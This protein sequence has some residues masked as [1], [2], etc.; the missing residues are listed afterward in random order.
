MQNSFSLQENK[1]SIYEITSDRR[2]A[3]PVRLSSVVPHFGVILS[4]TSFFIAA[5]YGKRIF[6]NK[7]FAFL[8]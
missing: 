8:I 3:K 2:V 6:R 4:Q 7:N 1:I 5:E